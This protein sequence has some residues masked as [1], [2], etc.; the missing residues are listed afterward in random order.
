MESYNNE[1][2]NTTI[3]ICNLHKKTYMFYKVLHK[4]IFEILVIGTTLCSD[5]IVY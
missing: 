2:T 5:E 3:T 1:N 4:N